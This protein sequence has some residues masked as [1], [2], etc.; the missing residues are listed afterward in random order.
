MLKK[1]V[2]LRSNKPL[3]ETMM[4]RESKQKRSVDLHQPSISVE[5]AFLISIRDTVVSHVE[6]F[7]SRKH[8]L[9]GIVHS[10]ML[11]MAKGVAADFEAYS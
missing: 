6:H 5:K 9:R 1:H 11:A 2:I 4:D 8:A 10:N 3:R 7:S